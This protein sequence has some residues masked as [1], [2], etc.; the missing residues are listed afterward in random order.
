[1]RPTVVDAVQ[2]SY[3]TFVLWTASATGRFHRTSNL[4]D[5]T[6]RYADLL[7]G[8][9][10]AYLSSRGTATRAHEWAA[11][12]PPRHHPAVPKQQ[13]RRNAQGHQVR[14]RC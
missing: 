13:R 5:M 14:V 9:K 3:D 6:A 2:E 1:M 4:F 10:V 12:T 7:T 11:T 8:D